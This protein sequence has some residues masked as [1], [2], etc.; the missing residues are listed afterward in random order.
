MKPET[1]TIITARG[2]SKSLPKKNIKLLCGKP[3]IF[4]QEYVASTM[5]A[6]F[7]LFELSISA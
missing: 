4:H 5:A 7:K 6:A 2:G 3:R 1:I